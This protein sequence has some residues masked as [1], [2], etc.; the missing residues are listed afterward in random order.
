MPPVCFADVLFVDLDGTLVATDV[1]RRALGM[2]VRRQPWELVVFLASALKGRAMAKRALARR[3]RPDPR[4]LPYHA[5]VLAFLR[6]EKARG[7][8]VV[9][10]TASDRLWAEPIAH[11][12]EL[13]NDVL[14]SDGGRNLKGVGKL[15]AIQT[16]CRERGFGAFAYIGDAMADVPI[17]EQAAQVYAVAP[18]RRVW[19][20]LQTFS[21]PVYVFTP[22]SS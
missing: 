19:A 10:A 21:Q 2:A 16:Y 20:A 17:W 18:A 5:E 3:L 8:P 12:V 1:M 14:A 4:Q 22:S 9:L 11:Y 13:F 6:A 15:N 7:V